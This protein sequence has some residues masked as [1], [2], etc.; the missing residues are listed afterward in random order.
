MVHALLTL[1]GKSRKQN[2][3]NWNIAQRHSWKQNPVEF[4][5]RIIDY[6]F[7]VIETEKSGYIEL[8]GS[9]NNRCL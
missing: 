7:L 8:K 1:I 3:T 6:V 9:L 2:Q 5:K 4:P